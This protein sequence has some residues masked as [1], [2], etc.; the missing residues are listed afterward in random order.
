M[1]K[2]SLQVTAFD[3]EE[4]RGVRQR[5]EL[6]WMLAFDGARVGVAATGSG[7][8]DRSIDRSALSALHSI[9]S[10]LHLPP[11]PSCWPSVLLTAVFCLPRAAADV[12]DHRQA[13]LIH[14]SIGDLHRPTSGARVPSKSMSALDVALLINARE[15]MEQDIGVTQLLFDITL[16]CH[17]TCSN[18]RQRSSANKCDQRRVRLAHCCWIQHQLTRPGSLS[19]VLPL[20]SCLARL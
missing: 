13:L 14:C 20:F 7:S 12:R 2:P 19:I 15:R 17:S 18:E 5:Q 16:A 9:L 10:C 4:E 8:I 3:Q 6:S 11:P 1:I